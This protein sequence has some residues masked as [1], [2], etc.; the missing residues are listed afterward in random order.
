MLDLLY[1]H[2]DT[3]VVQ[4]LYNGLGATLQG[5]LSNQFCA[6]ILANN[7]ADLFSESAG[8]I[9]VTEDISRRRNE[10]KR[11]ECIVIL[12]AM[13]GGAMNETSSRFWSDVIRR[14]NVQRRAWSNRREY[15]RIRY[16]NQV[17]PCVTSNVSSSK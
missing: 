16:T 4:Q 13:S 11:A 3:Q 7:L 2:K 6:S 17:G 15:R 1:F 10:T 12:G 14:N 5:F 8:S 9:D